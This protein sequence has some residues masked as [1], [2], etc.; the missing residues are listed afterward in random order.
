MAEVALCSFQ[1][2]Q[3]CARF[4]SENSPKNW[5]RGYSLSV[6]MTTAPIDGIILQSPSAIGKLHE[7]MGATCDTGECMPWL[8]CVLVQAYTAQMVT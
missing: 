2:Q 6:N 5:Q 7:F 3:H 8:S 4:S 1:E